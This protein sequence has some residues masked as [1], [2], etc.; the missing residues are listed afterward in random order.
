M[1]QN[2]WDAVGRNG[3]KARG[4]KLTS[5]GT[6]N[7][8]N[9]N[10]LALESLVGLDL[11]GST[12]G[13]TVSE[14]RSPGDVHESGVGNLV[15]LGDSLLSR[16]GGSHRS[17]CNFVDGRGS[18]SI[19]TS[20]SASWS[21]SKILTRERKSSRRGGGE[22]GEGGDES[23]RRSSRKHR[24]P[25]SKGSS[26]DGRNRGEELAYHFC[27]V[28]KASKLGFNGRIVDGVG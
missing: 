1:C 20:R 7:G 17:H 13:S 23:P 12:T 4:C 2:E 6:G 10:L 14:L 19:Q 24:R 5:V 9:D 21:G 8:N 16:G 18:E 15:A 25:L 22:G 11:G 26:S 27:D 3:V 28:A